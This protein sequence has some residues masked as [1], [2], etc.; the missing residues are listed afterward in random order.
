MG[1]A[2][3]GR[4]REVNH[5]GGMIA[6]KRFVICGL[7]RLATRVAPML[8]GRGAE[9]VVVRGAEG[10]DLVELLGP[11]V[12]WPSGGTDSLSASGRAGGGVRVV[13]AE[14]M[15]E[16]ALRGAGVGEAA[17]LLALAEDDLANLRAAV[18]AREIAPE[19]P[20]VLRAF[21][22]T[23]ADQLEEG[24]N[25]RR[26][27]SVS[28]LSAPTFV[29]EALAEEVVET[30]HL[31][32]TEVPICRLTVRAGSPME[33][34]T[35]RELKREFRCGVLACAGEDGVW[36]VAPEDARPLA[37]GDQV[38]VGGM[39]EDA[40]ALA[41]RNSPLFAGDRR[42]NRSWLLPGSAYRPPGSWLGRFGLGGAPPSAARWSGREP[43]AGTAATRRGRSAPRPTLL[44]RFGVG[45]GA[46]L[47]LAVAVF[48]LALKL[49]PVDALYFV[50]T[51]ATT[52]GY[53]D[54]SLHR[55]PPWLKLLGCLVMLSGGALLAVLFSHLASVATAE[56]LEEQMG[57]RA[58]QL[59]GHAV[60]AG[61]GNV[62][63]RVTR[64]LC[65]LGIDV[66]AIERTPE[67][68]FV[69]AVR[70][71]AAVLAG[72]ARLPESL[73]R[74]SVEQAAVFLAC[75]NDDLV[76]IQACLQAKR[77]NPAIRTVARIFDDFLAER[78]TGAFRID[79]AISSGKVAAR[80]FVSA[81]SDERALRP[82]RVGDEAFLAFRYE[83]VASVSLEEIEA[84][85]AEGLRVLAFRR[86]SGTV[87][88]PAELATGFQAGDTA[89]IAGPDASIRRLLL[90]EEVVGSRQ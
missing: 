85:R 52:T 78:L 16:A 63:Y 7:S 41:R 26:A 14:G 29:A 23:L 70:R 73:E 65:E 77:L 34:K 86:Q 74:A 45:L 15:R 40:L 50:V 88:S 20:V 31:G 62:G 39:L 76:N 19:V 17:C 33:G 58:Q 82:F 68:R 75:T 46:V 43:G 87:Q 66:A 49:S 79:A 6:G 24:L 71:Q 4:A 5:R 59:T 90:E 67:T 11:T 1:F 27:F 21:D 55:E 32:N 72:D 10:A 81:A 44:P 47:V 2:Q 25:I 12:A 30:L 8:A 51:T 83:A 54:I 89:I 61:L 38:L 42:R 37:V 3:G 9:V 22:P 48:S 80:A 53:G 57:R 60:V 64:L 36:Q 84:W 13:C 28:A 18:V 56:R 69:E 35:P